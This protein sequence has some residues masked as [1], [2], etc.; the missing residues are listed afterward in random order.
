MTLV[1]SINP[2]FDHEAEAAPPIYQPV[3]ESERRNPNHLTPEGDTHKL[4]REPACRQITYFKRKYMED[5]D[6]LIKFRSY[7]YTGSQVESLEEHSHVL[8]LSLD[9]MRFTDDP[10]AFLRRSVLINNLLRRL[11]TEILLHRAWS[12]MPGPAPVSLTMPIFTHPD[13]GHK[14]LRLLQEEKDECLSDCCCFYE[15]SRYVRFPVCIYKQKIEPSSSSPLLTNDLEQHLDEEEVSE[16]ER[17]T[18]ED[19]D[20]LCPGLDQCEAMLR[21]KQQSIKDKQDA[22][23]GN[24]NETGHQG[25]LVWDQQGRK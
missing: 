18:E 8:H 4:S 20:S 5:E 23:V 14:R 6:S 12:F 10:E 7:S 17:N 24:G 19:L 15:A 16:E 22:N 13:R 2:F 21:A 1:L 3:W 11:R 9:K 25:A